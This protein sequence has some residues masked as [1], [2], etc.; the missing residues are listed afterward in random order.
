MGVYT[1]VSRRADESFILFHQNMRCAILL[2]VVLGESEVDYVDLM[3]RSFATDHEVLRFDVSM[4]DAFF[5]QH[6]QTGDHL[7]RNEQHCSK[8]ESPLRHALL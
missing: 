5:V 3:V 1:R 2:E 7:V 6:L 4:D 8:G